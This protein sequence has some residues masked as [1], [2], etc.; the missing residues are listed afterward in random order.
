MLK[1]RRMNLRQVL[2][3]P[4]SSFTHDICNIVTLDSRVPVLVTSVHSGSYVSPSVDQI[5]LIPQQARFV[6]EDP[7]TDRF[8]AIGGV[9]LACRYSRFEFDLNRPKEK[10]VYQG[11]AEAWGLTPWG[12]QDDY[13]RVLCDGQ[14][15]HGEFYEIMRDVI[16][17]MG[18]RHGKLLHLNLHSFNHRRVDDP[19]ICISTEIIPKIWSDAVAGFMTTLRLA[20]Q[21]PKYTGTLLRPWGSVDAV[22]ENYPFGGGFLSQWISDQ[23]MQSVCSIQVEFNKCTFMTEKG[24]LIDDHLNSLVEILKIATSG[25][26]ESW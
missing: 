10:T 2:T 22:R 9:G 5:I 21:D 7:Y 25:L 12:S 4:L 23:F 13:Q 8:M 3:T 20:T 19:A 24:V 26:L 11:P 15:K 14:R 6:E 1:G 17:V 18:A 16:E